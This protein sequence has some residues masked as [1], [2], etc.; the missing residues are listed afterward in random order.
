VPLMRPRNPAPQAVG[1][2]QKR[3]F[4]VAIVGPDGAGKTT[5]ARRLQEV[6]PAPVAYIYMGI[7]PDS[8]NMMLPTTRLLHAVRR[9][10]GAQP[11][12]AG[13]RD[14][15][16]PDPPP[17]RRAVRGA[18]RT[19]RSF[20][21]LGNCLAEEWY[22]ALL[23]ARYRRRG[24]IVVF[25]RHFFADYY[26]YDVAHASRRTTS[27]RLHGFVLS[28]LY[29]QPDL[30]IYLDAPAAVLLERKGEGT[31]DSLAR[32]RDEYVELGGVMH[33]FALVDA[34]RPLDEVT[35]EVARLICDFAQGRPVGAPAPGSAS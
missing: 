24:A 29:P 3:A 28:R 21:R 14:S 32:R 18:L 17:P 9:A 22:R 8:S 10:R 27:R 31:L 19:S 1:A 15:R 20:L 12:R 7:N 4:T 2:A 35:E 26:A 6:L 11:D 30:T 25:D 33:S 16:R 5:V 34:S 13:P 23:A